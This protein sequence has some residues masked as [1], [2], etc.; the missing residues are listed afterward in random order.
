MSPENGRCWPASSDGAGRRERPWVP[1]T[2]LRGG[3]CVPDLRPA[4]APHWLPAC[5]RALPCVSGT[6]CPSGSAPRT[7]PR[8]REGASSKSPWL[9]PRLLYALGPVH[10]MIQQTRSWSD[11]QPRRRSSHRR[12][13]KLPHPRPRLCRMHPTGGKLADKGRVPSGSYR[14]GVW[15]ERIAIFF[16]VFIR[17]ENVVRLLEFLWYPQEE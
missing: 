15:P 1:D 10:P 13:R 2:P 11:S 3:A 9:R 16:T 6:G 14:E 4:P 7:A 5:Q 12:R 17:H 8:W